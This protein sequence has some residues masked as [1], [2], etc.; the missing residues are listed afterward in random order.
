[1]NRLNIFAGICLAGTMLAVPALAQIQPDV[2]VNPN[3][4]GT[5]VLLYPGGKYGR[6]QRP[7]LQPGDPDPNA[8]IVL[9]MPRKH[10]APRVAKTVV[11]PKTDVAAATP[12]PPPQQDYTP[13][14]ESAA[15]LIQSA[16]PPK[17]KP[18]APKPA[19]VPAPVKVAKQ[20]PPP[21]KPKPQPAPEPAQSF[22][23]S[24]APAPAPPPQH[25]A[26]VAPAETGSG[27]TRS[28]ILFAPG[29]EEPPASALDTVKGMAASLSAALW[30]GAASIQLEAYGGTHGDKSSDARRLSLKRALIVRQLLIDDGIPS[31]RIVVRAM[32]GASSGALDRVDIF[33]A[34]S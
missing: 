2:T 8:P 24:T 27:G 15:S 34:S 26:S 32:G 20:T 31:E 23:P 3:A 10:S 1:M 16:P 17:P 7:L 6:V 14:P 22:L 12:A 11:K 5:K 9:H 25:T 19:P 18:A 4:T 28:S 30:S 13:P 33:V 21:P 29:A